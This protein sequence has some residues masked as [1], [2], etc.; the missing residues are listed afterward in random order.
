MPVC[1]LVPACAP[2]ARF[3]LRLC[4]F[5]VAAR[6]I[7]RSVCLAIVVHTNHCALCTA[8]CGTVTH[9]DNWGM[10][11]ISRQ[12]LLIPTKQ[13]RVAVR[14]RIV[15]GHRRQRGPDPLQLSFAAVVCQASGGS[16]LALPGTRTIF[17]HVPIGPCLVHCRQPKG[18][19]GITPRLL[20]FLGATGV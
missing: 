2:P 16:L 14:S 19:K 8:R 10:T 1:L 15:G 3:K 7:F 18:S 20:M 4:S 17:L 11:M 5:L 9:W 13:A 6:M 12:S